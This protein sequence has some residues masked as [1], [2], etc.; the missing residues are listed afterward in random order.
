MNTGNTWR[1]IFLTIIVI[2]LLLTA[3]RQQK[4]ASETVSATATD[5]PLPEVTQQPTDLPTATSQPTQQATIV[6]TIQ[7][8]IVPTQ[9]VPTET[10]VPRPP[11]PTLDDIITQLTELPL[12]QFFEDSFKQLL[13][14]SPETIT[15]YGLAQTY[16]LGDAQLDN[17]SDEYIRETQEIEVAI[18]ELLRTY[19][20]DILESE[21]QVSYDVYEWYLENQVRGHEFMYHNYPVYH[22]YGSYNFSLNQL[23]VESHPLT[24]K[25]NVEDYISRLSQVDRQVDQLLGGLYLR[26]EMGIQP[27]KF[28]LEMTRDSLLANLQTDSL[29]PGTVNGRAL[30]LYYRLDAALAEID[31]LSEAEKESYRE[32]ALSEIENSLIPAYVALM[33]Y[34]DETM[35]IATNDAGVWQFDGGD[36]YY[37][38]LLHQETSTNLTPA[39]IHQM[40]LAE[41]ERIQGEMSTIFAELS[42][43]ADETTAAL[44]N[45]A[46]M[47]GGFY[48]T[49]SQSNQEQLVVELETIL[50]D[51]NQR[52]Q[53]VFDIQPEGDV[54]VVGDPSFSGGGYYE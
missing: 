3:C 45:R 18:L 20:R 33:E 31:T 24:T 39:E 43:P 26:S 37:T 53:A 46:M 1:K 8:T 36:S 11:Q 54:V 34:I 21:Q 5:E 38:H 14:R 50:E 52:M 32:A 10:A 47:D 42:Y 9:I 6:P 25:Q 41:V 16:G 48:E 22:F 13:L 29:A 19:N 23:F 4:P 17:L 49:T 15:Y 12:E 40:G 28:I 51:I 2:S 27:P 44:I 7:A 35:L 30:P